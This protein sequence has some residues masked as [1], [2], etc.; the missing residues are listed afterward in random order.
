ME[1]ESKFKFPTE[2]VELPSKGLIYPEN[3]PLHTGKIEIKYMSAREEDI[4]TNQNFVKQGIVI[5]KLLQS[6]II[7]KFNYDDLLIGDK[8][9]ILVAARIL[10]YGSNYEFTYNNEPQTVDL[11][12]LPTVELKESM[13]KDK[14]INAF[15]FTLPHSGNVITFK[16]LTTK[17]E[18]AIDAEVK[19][20]S[21]I[22]KN[23]SPLLSTR[24]KH[25]II[26]INGDDD[27]KSIREFV[28]TN[29]ITRD[30]SAFRMYVKSI[31]PTIKMTFRVN[32]DGSEEEVAIPM[33]VQF[34]WPDA[35]V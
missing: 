20:F 7:T 32:N 34:L 21:K 16:L 35:R 4:L 25:Q 33:E 19:G 17:D 1:K 5:D 11:S 8:N 15:D 12:Q 3:H 31:E 14:G 29:F 6:L 10:A 13:L 9:A 2:T 18:K 27:P 23:S 26:A 30:S 22:N 24:Y 28:D